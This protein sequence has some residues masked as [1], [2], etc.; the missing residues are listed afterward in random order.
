MSRRHSLEIIALTLL[1]GTL[2]LACRD[3]SA[4]RLDS[5][6]RD[7][8]SPDTSAISD[9]GPTDS[10][11]PSDRHPEPRDLVAPNETHSRDTSET[12]PL[13][14]GSPEVTPAEETTS[15]TASDTPS[16]EHPCQSDED[17]RWL[18][19][20]DDPCL[21]AT[22]DSGECRLERLSD[23]CRDDLDCFDWDPCT[24]SHCV[25]ERCVSH[26]IEDDECCSGEWLLQ[27]SFGPDAAEDWSFEGPEGDRARFHLSH[28]RVA[29]GERAL[30]FSYPATGRYESDY[31]EYGT[32]RGPWVS[33]P[34]DATQ[35]LLRFD[36]YLDTEW[37]NFTSHQW[38]DPWPL[39]YDRL[40]L[41][42]E[43]G[44]ESVKVW[45]S[46][47]EDV[48]G[49]TCRPVGHPDGCRFESYAVD[50]RPFS[51]RTVRPV[52][53]F[54]TGDH[55]DNDY[56][57]PVI[58]NVGILLD[59]GPPPECLASADC[60]DGDPCTDGTCRDNRCEFEPNY[61]PGCCYDY[62]H[63]DW[64]FDP[65]SFSGFTPVPADSIVRWHPSELRSVTPPSS[66]RFGNVVNETYDLPGEAVA[67]TATSSA[68]ALANWR[69]MMLY[70]ELFL[71]IEPFDPAVPHRD[72]FRIIVFD[73][74]GAPFDLDNAP[75]TVLWERSE[76]SAEDYRTW[77]PLA[78]SLDDVAG[79]VIRL[80][81]EFSS[82]DAE[83]NTGQG[84]FIDSVT[85]VRH[86]D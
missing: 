70:L 38:E 64:Q 65:L 6:S 2:G 37:R 33:V 11:A 86:C 15:D 85:I 5:G 32:A 26:P 4:P 53:H 12:T 55:V 8:A 43:D 22:C 62:V 10:W 40:T 57:G 28:R 19:P 30:A 45:T 63:A 51:G 84:V 14:A 27:E 35:P 48:R 52:F 66:L 67:G 46:Y 56:E 77:V 36:L 17:C 79:R 44:D 74:T 82:G 39:L 78:I 69:P 18:E 73:V 71:D 54:D 81:F 21:S 49:S 60:D 72:L 61:R 80:R 7:V 58:D 50:L 1:L 31:R 25:D 42:L 16:D 76:L 59:C 3:Q 83:G 23:C 29:T 13:D 75:S 34:E 68:V 47:S 9:V 24:T 20:P 41:E